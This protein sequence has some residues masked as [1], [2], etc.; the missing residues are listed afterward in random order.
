MNAE[1]EGPFKDLDF[2]GDTP[3]LRRFVDLI[4]LVIVAAT[5]TVMIGVM[6]ASAPEY[7]RLVPI[8]ATLLVVAVSHWRLRRSPRQAIAVLAV[9]MWLMNAGGVIAFAGIHSAQMI[10]FPF[11]LVMIGWVLGLRWLA[12][13]TGLTL[14]LVVVLALA[15][16]GGLLQ[17]TPR[18]PALRPILASQRAMLNKRSGI[19]TI[20]YAELNSTQAAWYLP[21]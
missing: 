6:G 12:W 8:G 1:N 7:A 3:R 13:T 20:W 9:G 18:A 19:S 2:L 15:E 5:A 4:H 11:L 16:S 21:A 10:V 14:A 17:P